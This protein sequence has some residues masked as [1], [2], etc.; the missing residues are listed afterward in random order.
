MR[1][2]LFF[3]PEFIVSDSAFKNMI[4]AKVVKKMG[5]TFHVAYSPFDQKRFQRI[6][7]KLDALELKARV[8]LLTEGLRAEL[9][10]K[11]L[12]D[13]K[14]LQKVLSQKKLSGFELWPVSEYISQ[15][16]TDHFEKSMGLM[17]EMTQAFTSEFAIRPFLQKNPEAILGMLEKWIED[18]NVHIRRWVSEGTRPL[19]PWGGKIQ[20]F[21][22]KP[23]TLHLLEKLKYD[24]ELYVRKSVAN[25][26]NDIS[27]NH[28]ELLVKT[29]KT[30]VKE[31]PQEHKSKIDWIK[32]Q[33]LRTLI[34]K[35][36]IGALS[37]MGVTGEAKVNLKN[38]KLNQKNYKVGDTLAFD[39]SLESTSNKSQD[40]IVDYLINFVKVNGTRSAKVFKLKAMT[41]KAGEK[42][43]LKK[44]HSLKKITTM[45]FF[46]GE[47]EVQ[48]Q[49]NGKVI[50]K[51]SWMFNP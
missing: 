42:V 5:A 32:K 35:G 16:G 21:V 33:A 14:V 11:F 41:L 34:K 36:H 28:P 15:F 8:L 27:K 37:L 31:A 38:L 43:V 22:K 13:A 7:P 20:S 2:A 51:A 26:L 17:Y 4:N 6:I 1:A 44:N 39:F 46:K 3:C 25:H 18:E 29:L 48:I 12:E 49:I 19:L 23:A 50:K 24:E 45:R 30:W 40:L 10:K 9:P 47:H